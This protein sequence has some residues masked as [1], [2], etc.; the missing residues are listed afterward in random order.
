MKIKN[1]KARNVPGWVDGLIEGVE[2]SQL[3]AGPG[4]GRGIIRSATNFFA[5]R[6]GRMAVRGGSEVI[7][8]LHES[9]GA[10]LS[11]VLSLTPYSQTGA[12][13]V[14]HYATGSKHYLYRLTSTL[15][16]STGVE[17]TSRHDLGWNI[18]TP[19][20]P[21][22]AELFEKL[23]LVDGTE[24][25]SA[26]QSLV[27][28]DSAGVVVAPTYDLDGNGGTAAAGIKAYCIAAFNGVL[29]VAGYDSEAVGAGRAPHLVRHSFLGVKPSLAAGF[30]KDAYNTI[31]SQGLAVRAMVPGKKI[32]LLAKDNELH[33]LTGSGA[34]LSGWRYAVAQVDN[35]KG[36]GV[37]NPYA[38]CHRAGKWYGV[39]QSGPFITDAL[40]VDALAGYRAQSW[41]NVQRLDTAFVVEH[42]AREAILFGFNM[43]GYSG[44]ST[45]FPF[46]LW[47][48]DC[49]R[50]TWVSDLDFGV[51]F[52][53]V[54]PIPPISTL[55][56]TPPLS[57]PGAPTIT[58]ASAT[59]T[60]VTGVASLGDATAK[61]EVR[62]RIS[63]S[64]AF[65]SVGQLLDPGVTA[66]TIPGLSPYTH[67]EIQC[68]H[69]KSGIYSAASASAD[70]YTKLA[71]PSLI[72]W[73]GPG[74]PE[75]VNIRWR[76]NAGG[77][78]VLIERKVSTDPDINY[79]Q[80]ID[81]GAQ[82]AGIGLSLN[83]P[84]C[85]T[86]YRFRDRS[87]DASWPAAIQY[88]DYSNTDDAVAC[89]GESDPGDPP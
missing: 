86:T 70:A 71:V 33:A 81:T 38:L 35:S 43:S 26:R 88:S 62:Y 14:G 12:A 82:P 84:T 75:R 20:R 16:F 44:R 15:G 57:P 11:K 64:G 67:Y 60:S 31:G 30:D 19:A 9:G 28:V 8:S 80:V 69:V 32:L 76:Q 66:F 63:G 21:V 6:A 68:A 18:A 56:S 59:T 37:A 39:G 29:F 72:A 5:T 55:T 22:I 49:L 79:A 58:H 45:Q 23:Y 27:E 47:V 53:Y 1:G 24:D 41:R 73:G 25:Y 3:E 51:N 77:S 48:W 54:Q 61:T 4:V 78:H 74:L 40:T 17:A 13:A 34:G 36:F 50:E 87:Y 83:N 7:R 46:I 65:F 89:A 42:P 52:A 2:P 85:G 10:A